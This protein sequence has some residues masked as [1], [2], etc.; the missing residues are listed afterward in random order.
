MG[1]PSLVGL[2]WRVGLKCLEELPYPAGLVCLLGLSNLEGLS[3][4]VAEVLEVVRERAGGP[5]AGAGV[6]AGEERGMSSCGGE[7][8]DGKSGVG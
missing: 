5:D 1:L 3:S 6:G 2:R 4:L 8:L 7:S